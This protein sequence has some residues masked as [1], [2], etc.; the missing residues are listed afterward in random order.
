MLYETLE[1]AGRAIAAAKTLLARRVADSGQS[2][3]S[4]DPSLS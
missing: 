1:R 2:D 4:G 3:R